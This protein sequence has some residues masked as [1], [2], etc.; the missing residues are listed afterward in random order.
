MYYLF[1]I[2]EQKRCEIQLKEYFDSKDL[3]SKYVYNK[4]I[5]TTRYRPDFCF[6]MDDRN[7]IVEVDEVHHYY[8]KNKIADFHRMHA[9]ALS[10]NKKHTIFIRVQGCKGYDYSHRHLQEIMDTI[11]LYST[12]DTVTLISMINVIYLHFSPWT[13]HNFINTFNKHFSSTEIDYILN[14]PQLSEI[15]EFFEKRHEQYI[16]KQTAPYTN[17]LG[18]YIIDP[19]DIEDIDGI[20]SNDPQYDIFSEDYNQEVDPNFDWNDIV[21]L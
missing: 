2:M 15:N 4:K 19:N 20:E 13:I 9:I 21:E 12:M 1:Y 10:D 18:N 16:K 5:G 8:N 3:T 7:V 11:I 14:F 6:S 17:S